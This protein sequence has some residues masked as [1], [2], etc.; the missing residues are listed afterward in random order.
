[1]CF[2]NLIPEKM[3]EN[4]IADQKVYLQQVRQKAITQTLT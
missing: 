1:M 2:R 3:K 4:Q